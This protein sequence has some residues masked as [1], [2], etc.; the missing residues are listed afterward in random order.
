MS[1][2]TASPHRSSWYPIGSFPTEAKA[3][4]EAIDNSIKKINE[5]APNLPTAS[6]EEINAADKAFGIE[7]A[8]ITTGVI[9][10]SKSSSL[11][12][13]LKSAE[14]QIKASLSKLGTDYKKAF[15]ALKCP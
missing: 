2:R 1:S 7:I 8:K 3:S 10:A 15:E 5:G 4:V 11:E 14:P 9:S 13:G 12:A 6:K